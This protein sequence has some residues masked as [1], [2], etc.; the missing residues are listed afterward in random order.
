[1]G[2]AELFWGWGDEMSIRNAFIA[3][4]ALVFG[5]ACVGEASAQSSLPPCPFI[6]FWDR[7][8]GTYTYTWPDGGGT[9]VGEFRDNQRNG[10]GTYTWP[11][12]RKY[13]GQ[14]RDDQPN[15]QGT[16]YGPTAPGSLRVRKRQPSENG[17]EWWY[18]SRS[19][20]HK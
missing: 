16:Y 14:F 2:I 12:G 9:Y 15:G 17:R 20:C 10:Q 19:C 3:S 18:L 13:V 7:C 1:M 6:G 8:I 11:D 5:I 4:I